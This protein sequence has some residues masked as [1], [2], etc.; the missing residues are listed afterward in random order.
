[1]RGKDKKEKAFWEKEADAAAKGL[2]FLELKLLVA[3]SLPPYRVF[4]LSS[5]EFSKNV[6]FDY[7]ACSMYAAA[8]A[9]AATPL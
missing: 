9:P 2:L 4:Q 8:A 6:H 5:T 1:V 3:G 7:G